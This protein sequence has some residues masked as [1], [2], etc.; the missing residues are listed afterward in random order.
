MLFLLLEIFIQY[1]VDY[2]MVYHFL[3]HVLFPI[4]GMEKPQAP[5]IADNS[6]MHSLH[7]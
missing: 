3:N 1:K 7:S 2:I 4:K 5:K 6:K